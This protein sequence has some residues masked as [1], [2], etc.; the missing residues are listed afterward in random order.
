MLSSFFV[1]TAFSTKV[2]LMSHPQFTVE[3]HLAAMRPRNSRAAP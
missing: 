1:S 2:L 3:P